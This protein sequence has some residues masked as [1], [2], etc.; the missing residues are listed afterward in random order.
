M[1]ET[2]FTSKDVI[3]ALYEAILL[4]EPDASGLESYSTPI[5][6]D[7]G[8]L[9]HIISSLLTSHESVVKNI[10]RLNDKVQIHKPEWKNASK[11]ILVIGNCQATVL[12][13]Q[14]QL[15]SNE[16]ACHGMHVLHNL[17][18]ALRSGMLDLTPFAQSDLV[19][20]QPALLDRWMP[21]VE[22]QI[23]DIGAK[24]RKIPML[25]FQGFH[26]DC[27]YVT[28]GNKNLDSPV[29][30]Y[31]S[32]I[33]FLGWKHGLSVAQTIKLFGESTFRALG[34]FEYWNSSMASLRIEGERTGFE[35][36][37]LSSKWNQR[38]CWMHTINHPHVAV[39][40]DIASEALAR[41]GISQVPYQ[42]GFFTDPLVNDT[43][44]PVYPEL[45]KPLGVDGSYLFKKHNRFG[46]A[47]RPVQFLDLEQFAVE[48]Y[49]IYDQ[50]DRSELTCD[51]LE[52][53][54][55]R[56]L[57]SHQVPD[58]P[59]TQ[60]FEGDKSSGRAISPYTDLPDHQYWSRAVARI[61][62]SAVDP[63]IKAGFTLQ[64]TDRIATA[65]S[66]FAQHISRTLAASGFNYF[67]AEN[68][69]NLPSAVAQARNFGVFS[70]R[71]GNI[72]TARQ[73]L[74][75]FNQAYGEFTPSE[76][77]WKRTDGKLVDPFRPLIEPNGFDTVDAV[78]TSRE[79]HL[80]CVRS[81]FEQLDVFVFTLGLTEAWRSREDGAVFPIAP[82]VAGGQWD[83][84]R[85]EFINF[86][87][88]DV[89]AD[90][91]T[92]IAKL[93]K[94]NP[95]A[96]IIL[97]VSPVPLV[98]TYEN[99]HVLVSTTYSKAALRAAADEI[100]RATESCDYFPS[101]EVITGNFSRGDYYDSDLRTI[102]QEGVDHVMR[103]F[104]A[105]YADA[106]LSAA[107]PLTHKLLEETERLRNV[108]CDEE[109]IERR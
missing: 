12:A 71:F 106:P 73:L 37:R 9:T 18:E 64:R 2:K 83:P 63:M 105:H 7:P 80:A 66:C 90:M 61:E 108:V 84:E 22:K 24:L 6:S 45:G 29:G 57:L 70:A 14:M 23:P 33:I 44:W 35:L 38:G 91:Q 46:S 3:K 82:G 74:Q 48:S 55:F 8:K 79:E 19:F 54:S 87:A 69:R 56:M 50:Y 68:S 86:T 1:S 16:V 81:M 94:R 15:V 20:A 109:A 10:P 62:K 53:P 77:A 58:E 76:G 30:A 40:S 32:S 26:P 17:T 100:T 72:Y 85:Y 107:A 67:V 99:R 21:F 102:R 49:Q 4:R 41:E 36:D 39:L 11:K 27:I 92:F 28:H 47:E 34:F 98:A 78:G 25:T 88:N 5:D 42:S 75:L 96:K 103:L 60:P 51:R 59:P 52:S 93:R 65:G 13:T 43:V 89:A 104:L 95:T 101:F 97:T 31:H